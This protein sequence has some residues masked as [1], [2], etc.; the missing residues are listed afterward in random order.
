[1]FGDRWRSPSRLNQHLQ[2][3]FIC[4]ST[5]HI[6][7]NKTCSKSNHL[8][9]YKQQNTATKRE[10]LARWGVVNPLYEAKTL[11]GG[12]QKMDLPE[13]RVDVSGGFEYAKIF[14][15]FQVISI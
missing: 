7:K 9:S 5:K 11:A 1:L 4:N 3:F 14:S 15:L 2:P 8:H 12:D 6:S 13:E 10:Y